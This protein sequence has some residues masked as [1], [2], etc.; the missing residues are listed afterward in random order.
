MKFSV[1]IRYH[2]H[3]TDVKA[4]LTRIIFIYAMTT[5]YRDIHTMSLSLALVACFNDRPILAIDLWKL[6]CLCIKVL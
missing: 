4:Y 3:Y 2:D 5:R 1:S 6:L